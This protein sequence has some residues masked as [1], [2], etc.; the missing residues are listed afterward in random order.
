MNVIAPD[1]EDKTE[2]EKV[3]RLMAQG[4]LQSVRSGEQKNTYDNS[5][6]VE[7]RFST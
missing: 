3:S 6:P 4:N 2:M 1:M 5:V 7:D